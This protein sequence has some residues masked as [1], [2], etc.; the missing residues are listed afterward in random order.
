[1]DSTDSKAT[2]ARHLRDCITIL[3]ENIPKKR[4]RLV[5]VEERGR[6]NHTIKNHQQTNTHSIRPA[7]T[8]D[9]VGHELVQEE[10]KACL[11]ELLPVL[12]CG[13]L[14]APEQAVAHK[15]LTKKEA[16]A[17]AAALDLKTKGSEEKALD[18]T[19]VES[20][21]LEKQ[22]EPEEK[23][24]EDPL[25]CYKKRLEELKQDNSML[26]QRRRDAFE[27]YA[28]LISKY[29]YGLNYISNLGSLEES[30]DNVMDGNFATD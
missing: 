22:Q 4:K 20:K 8:E 14:V 17:V 11:K 13:P 19:T 29:E 3:Q 5:T 2:E 26:E 30:P 15:T 27:S 1:M 18:A 7:I 10:R 6:G 21:S 9:G 16:E 25:M 28:G 24:E 12:I 23:E